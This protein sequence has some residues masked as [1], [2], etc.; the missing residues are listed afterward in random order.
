MN[1]HIIQKQMMDIRLHSRDQSARAI[2]DAISSLCQRKVLPS[3]LRVC[4]GYSDENTVLKIDR[5]ELEIPSLTPDELEEQLPLKIQE[6]FEKALTQ[7]LAESAFYKSMARP[8]NENNSIP[9]TVSLSDIKAKTVSLKHS[10]RE[11]LLRFLRTGNFPWWAVEKDWPEPEKLLE[12]LLDD[13]DEKQQAFLEELLASESCK[14]RLTWQFSPAL[15]RKVIHRWKPWYFAVV[16]KI[17]RDLSALFQQIDSSYT[18]ADFW[19]A[20]LDY[21]DT[22]PYSFQEEAFVENLIRQF[23]EALQ[24]AFPELL[25]RCLQ[26]AKSSISDTRLEE[27]L[28]TLTTRYSIADKTRKTGVSKNEEKAITENKEG[29][30]KSS[31]EDRMKSRENDEDTTSIQKQAGHETN[32]ADP[33]S[34]E[35]ALYIQNAGVVLFWPYLKTF[36]EQCGLVKEN[37]FT[38]PQASYRAAHLLQYLATGK[39]YSPEFRLPLNKILCGI[40]MQLPVPLD[41]NLTEAEKKDCLQLTE[42]LIGNWEALKNTSPEGLRQSFL[43][44]PGK[45]SRKTDHWHLKVEQKTWD[46]LLDKIPWPLSTIKLYWM[47]TL[48]HVEWY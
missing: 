30:K 43:L 20:V 38:D 29:T 44:R 42:S 4:D 34:E 27:L 11:L 9:E 12:E 6:A 26:L 35:E 47:P 36:F 18:A 39:T 48:I 17:S 32:L 28:Q 3:L 1:T 19:L 10:K 25:D 5:L 22:E 23:A 15:V 16:R 33:L 45:L 21:P 13:T 46:V 37:T 40:P 24:Q 2:Q 31:D 7:G 8:S 41:I 14:K